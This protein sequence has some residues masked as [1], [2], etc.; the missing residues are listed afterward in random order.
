MA[1]I[2]NEPEKVKEVETKKEV[3]EAVNVNF[4]WR[5][6]SEN[7]WLII[8]VVCIAW[9]YYFNTI[10]TGPIIVYFIYWYWQQ[11]K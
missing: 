6:I 9:Y 10:P 11:T 7:S 4:D 3:S 5:I 2:I 8:L 1:W